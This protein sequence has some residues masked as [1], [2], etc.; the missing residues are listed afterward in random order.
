MDESDE[1]NVIHSRLLAF[2]MEAWIWCILWIFHLFLCDHKGLTVET[3]ALKL[4]TVAN[5][6]HQLGWW[7]HHENKFACTC[8][9]GFNR[10]YPFRWCNLSAEF[11]INLPVKLEVWRLMTD[12]V[13]FDRGTHYSRRSIT[14]LL[15]K[16][17]TCTVVS[18]NRGTDGKV[19]GSPDTLQQPN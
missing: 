4:F 16:R 17:G 13:P 7:N 10:D 2:D 6:H 9:R 11:G 18:S 1:L 8:Q 14:R 3:S 19:G 5:L 12:S 15:Q